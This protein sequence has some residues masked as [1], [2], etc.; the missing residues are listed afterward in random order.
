MNESELARTCPTRADGA[1]ALFTHRI[2]TATC[3]GRQ[4]SNYHKCFSCEHFEHGV[5]PVKA[6]LPPLPELELPRVPRQGKPAALPSE[7]APAAARLKV[8]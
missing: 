1:P 5:A 4:S 6:S 7:K 8:G 3:A 2:Q